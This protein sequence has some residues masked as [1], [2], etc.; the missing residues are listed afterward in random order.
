LPDTKLSDIHL[1]TGVAGFVGRCLTERLLNEGA[2]VAGFDNL[3]RGTLRNMSAFRD[4]P[5]FLFQQTELTDLDAYLAAF[6]HAMQWSPAGRTIVWHL[7]ANSDIQ[8]GVRDPGVDLRDTFLTTFNTL[9]MMRE[10]ALT[11]IVFAST[12]AVYGPLTGPLHEDAGPLFPISSYGA[13]KLASEASISAAAESFLSHAWICRFPNVI[14][15]YAT[16]GVIYDF[17]NKLQRSPGELEV[18]GDGNQC[19]PYLLVD[20][21]VDAMLFISANSK[22]RLNY[23]NIGPPDSGVTVRAIAEE[24]VRV[25]APGAGIRYTGGDRGWVGDVPRFNYSIAKLQKLGWHPRSSSE[26]AVK[27]AVQALWNDPECRQ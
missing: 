5:R 10:R 19:K 4:S 13:M 25:A 12:S 1:I 17:L 24:V 27:A 22:D 15:A 3:S 20:E 7:A 21:L 26:Q 23:F 18:L 8:A 2:F 9:A 16:H 11:E 14:G 6:D